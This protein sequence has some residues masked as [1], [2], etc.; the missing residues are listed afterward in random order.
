VILGYLYKKNSS[1]S[2]NAELFIKDNFYSIKSNNNLIDDGKIESLSISSR[3]G[4]TKRKITL[5]NGEVFMTDENDLIDLYLI[6]PLKKNSLLH[7]LE[8]HLVLVFISILFTLF[9]VFSFFKWGVPYISGKLAFALPSELN[10]LISKNTLKTLDKHF[11]TKSKLLKQKKEQI[12]ISFNKD[13]LPHIKEKSFKYKLHFR[14]W[15]INNTNIPNAFALPN[16]DIVLTDEF[17]K[18]SKNNNEINSVIFHEIGHVV[19]RH[20][21]KRIIENS[22][23]SIFAMYITGDGTFFSDLGVGIGSL[24]LNTNFSRKH[25]I[26][27]DEF[28]FEMMLKSKINPKNFSSILERITLSR[29]EEKE[30]IF[31]YF[32]SHPTNKERITLANKYVSCYKNNLTICN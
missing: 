19:H 9:T 4:N 7:K 13:V 11:F 31:D 20:G 17:I 6:Q 30:T 3:L 2:E 28:A 18:L 8:S 1:T 27:A 22:F 23:V 12:L 16:G 26:E 29:N 21:L 10:T 25:E 32:S 24:F 14:N 5:E 15:Q